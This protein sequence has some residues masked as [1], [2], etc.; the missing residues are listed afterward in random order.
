MEGSAIR[1][2]LNK[3]KK[4]TIPRNGPDQIHTLF[5]GTERTTYSTVDFTILEKSANAV[6]DCV[7]ATGPMACYGN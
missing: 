2:G 1:A 4:K 5:Y 6:N 3:K 7:E